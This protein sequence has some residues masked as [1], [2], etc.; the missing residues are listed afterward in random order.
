MPDHP[1]NKDSQPLISPQSAIDELRAGNQ[2]FLNH[3]TLERDWADDI[4]KTTG[5]QHPFAIVI[6][7]IDSR[8]PVETIFDQGIGDIFTARV[9]GNI[10][11]EDLLGSLEFAC[12][13]AG[14]KAIVVLGHTSCGAI[15]GAIDGVRLGHLTTLLNKI[16]PII[17]KVSAAMDRDDPGFA[18]AVA[19]ANI[20]N[21]VDVIRDNSEI[22]VRMESSGDIS[23]VG[24]MY[25]VATGEVCFY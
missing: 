17:D 4:S 20:V 19:E 1:L 11:N 7:C 16:E 2:R 5:G 8:V 18:D 10:V 13:L 23:I 6:G 22:L 3:S 24:A 21:T 9:A 15:K 14:A 12:K 25:N